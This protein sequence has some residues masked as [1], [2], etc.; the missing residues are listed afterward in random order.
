MQILWH[1]V[2]II[3]S[4]QSDMCSTFHPTEGVPAHPKC[5]YP[6]WATLDRPWL[7]ELVFKILLICF[8][9]RKAIELGVLV[10]VAVVD[11]CS[12]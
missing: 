3:Y 7:C 12:Q 5:D 10:V 4:N 1:T 9:G 6:A 8:A 2:V 11:S